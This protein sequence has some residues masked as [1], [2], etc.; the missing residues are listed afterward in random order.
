MIKE[1]SFN[2][3]FTNVYGGELSL[4]SQAFNNSIVN[5]GEIPALEGRKIKSIIVLPN[6]ELTASKTGKSS[7]YNPS[8]SSIFIT[9]YDM[10]RN[11]FIDSTPVALFFPMGSLALSSSLAV[12]GFLP[13]IFKVPRVVSWSSSYLKI[14]TDADNSSVNYVVDFI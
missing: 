6:I 12:S 13:L 4:S 5:F 2:Y 7:E 14:E 1:G 3:E 11:V 10:D 8:N 9:L